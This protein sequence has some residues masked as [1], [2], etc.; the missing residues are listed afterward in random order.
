M[1]PSF[2]SPSTTATPLPLLKGTYVVSYQR[3]C[4]P[5]LT[6]S[7]TTNGS[8][9]SVAISGGSNQLSRGTITFVQS[10]TL[11]QGTLTQNMITDYGSLFLVVNSGGGTSGTPLTAKSNTG[12]TSFTQ[13]ATTFNIKDGNTANGSTFNIYYGQ[14]TGTGTST[15]V[16][17]AVFGGIDDQGCAEQGTVDIN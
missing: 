17:H 7:R 11:G 8:V 10:K 16:Q 2:M 4:Q 9:T 13:T 1:Y 6:A 3:F 5:T 14:V 12:S 15:V